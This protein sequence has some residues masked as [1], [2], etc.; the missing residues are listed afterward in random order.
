MST[1]QPELVPPLFAMGTSVYAR[2]DE[3]IL[4]LK[5]AGGAMS[6]SWYLPGGALDPDETLERCA[7]RELEEEAGLVPAGPLAL[8]GIVPM[9]I[10]GR[11]SLIVGYACDVKPG[12]VKLSHEH[13][14]WRWIRPEQFREEF[15]AEE[16]VRAIEARNERVGSIVRGIQQDL[17]RY[18]AWL[19]RERVFREAR[20]R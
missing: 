5:R 12:A 2:R 3:E 7:A 17:D 15:F 11:P 8:I 16:S 4:I 19:E 14:D 13:S 6:G 1:S 9:H 20:A 18:L 10:Y